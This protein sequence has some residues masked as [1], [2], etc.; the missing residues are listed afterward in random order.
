MKKILAT[1]LL[2]AL[3]FAF[4][5]IDATSSQEAPPNPL[6]G[7]IIALDAGH[8][9]DS[10]GATY[11]PN[12]GIDGTVAEKDVNIATVFALQAKLK[13]DGA[14]VAL[15]RECDET[16][17]RRKDR[18]DT[19]K[20]KCAALDIDKNGEPDGKECDVLVSVHHNGSSDESYDGMTTIY[21][22]KE[23]LV[24]ATYLHDGLLAGLFDNN[25][26]YDE[27]YERGG[28]GMT[29]YF[30]PASLTE[31]YYVTNKC[32]AELFLQ[33]TV[34]NKEECSANIYGPTTEPQTTTFLC[35]TNGTTH[36]FEYG[37]G[38]VNQEAEALYQGL[39][40]Y[41]SSLDNGGGNGGGKDC[42]PG[43]EKQGKC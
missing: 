3:S 22:N 40:D 7:K 19:A 27:E 43:K 33:G 12:T 17:P 28:Y 6:Y 21:N 24:L 13:A 23:D 9:G 39:I 26:A 1:T 37:P 8:G 4:L 42:P 38:R 30:T 29:V 10:L 31:G 25:P 18:V 35:A 34:S 20:K 16:I 14:Y 36:N 41:F 2:M 32:E 11:P 5:S 15:T